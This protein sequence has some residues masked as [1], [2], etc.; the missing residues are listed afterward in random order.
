MGARTP[1]AGVLGALLAQLDPDNK[2]KGTQFEH[3]CK[4]FLQNDPVY[5]HELKQVWLWKEWPDRWKEGEAGIDLV[6]KHQDGTLWAIQA[7]AYAENG[8][9]TMHDISQFLAESSRSIFS[10]RLMIMTTNHLAFNAKDV[11]KGSDKDV[12]IVDRADLEAAQVIWPVSLSHLR[13]PKPKPKKPWP[14]PAKRSTP[15]CRALSRPIAVR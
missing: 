9:V 3:I 11:A 14:Q 10:Y 4:W 12:G 2:I 13:A 8:T 1:R 6:A 15:S 5:S 7:K